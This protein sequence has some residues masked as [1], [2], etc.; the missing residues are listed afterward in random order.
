LFGTET[1]VYRNAY[2]K[3]S[4]FGNE[5]SRWW[6]VD[7]SY[8]H[9]GPK[10]PAEVPS[11]YVVNR[12]LDHEEA[13]IVASPKPDDKQRSGYDLEALAIDPKTEAPRGTP[14]SGRVHTERDTIDTT[15]P[16]NQGHEP[17]IGEYLSAQPLSKVKTVLRALDCFDGSSPSSSRQIKGRL[18]CRRQT[19]ANSTSLQ[20]KE[21]HPAQR[22]NETHD[23]KE[24][25]V[26][27]RD[28]RRDL[29]T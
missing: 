6:I 29:F 1:L 20:M 15:E 22:N 11:E 28:A 3:R 21:S 14:S 7:T 24:G 9:V 17:R 12:F 16:F 5:H 19:V 26:R 2:M 4:R 25:E 27:Y 10:A 13:K 23:A 8:F 18:R